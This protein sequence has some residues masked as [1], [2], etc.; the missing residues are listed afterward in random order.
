MTQTAQRSYLG[1]LWGLALVGATLDLASK[2]LVFGWLHDQAV[3]AGRSHGEYD[4]VPG[5]FKLLSQ[6]T[7]DPAPR[8]G[9][10]DPFLYWGSDVM[11]RVNHGALFG[12]G[13]EYVQLANALF[14]TVS[15][16]AAVAIFFWGLRPAT[17]RDWSL[18]AALG[19]ILAGTLGNLYDRLVFHGVRDFLYFYWIEWPV[20]NLADCCLVCGAGLLLVQ[21]FFAQP[22]SRDLPDAVPGVVLAPEAI[23][24]K[25]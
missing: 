11:P 9:A 12:L 22:A 17:A 1:L 5:G 15:V 10:L 13:G 25:S 6:F 19:L 20:F 16:L 8:G 4:L 14:S 23:E 7:S 2:Y 3:R 24:V 18:C 21:A